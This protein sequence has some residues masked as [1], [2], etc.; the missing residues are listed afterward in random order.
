MHINIKITQFDM[1][2]VRGNLISQ[3]ILDLSPTSLIQ[4][5]TSPHINLVFFVFLR[6]TS[7]LNSFKA[8][9]PIVKCIRVMIKMQN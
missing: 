5:L 9:I 4:S 1:L 7:R 6:L 3:E 8:L 2:K